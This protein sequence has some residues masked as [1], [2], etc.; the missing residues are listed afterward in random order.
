MQWLKTHKKDTGPF[1]DKTATDQS[2]VIST[3]LI[4]HPSLFSPSTLWHSLANC[5]PL[6]FLTA[7]S[8]KAV[9]Q[10]LILLTVCLYWRARWPSRVWTQ[11]PWW[12]TGEPAEWRQS[13][14]SSQRSSSC[15]T[16]CTHL[17]SPGTPPCHQLS[18]C[19][20][21][22]TFSSWNNTTWE[23]I[24]LD[25]LVAIM[26][27]QNREWNLLKAQKHKLQPQPRQGEH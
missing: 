24:V 1:K 10:I 8:W 6:H 27:H 20:I 19:H 9:W 12:T 13:A 23:C 21:R 16:S 26:K 17:W 25:A 7:D 3:P 22:R 11:A 2:S 14:H 15:P 5:P 18:L 4:L